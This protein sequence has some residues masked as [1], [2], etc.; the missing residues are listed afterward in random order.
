[1][2]LYLSTCI[3]SPRA[4]SNTQSGSQHQPE[5]LTP[6]CNNGKHGH[7]KQ[8]H[9]QNQSLIDFLNKNAWQEA[10][11]NKAKR[12]RGKQPGSRI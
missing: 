3:N 8:E 4:H 10:T 11:S 5:Q 6:G 7:C 1:M 12:N 9:E 2:Y